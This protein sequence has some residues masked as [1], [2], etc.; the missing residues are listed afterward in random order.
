MVVSVKVRPL[1]VRNVVPVAL[2]ITHKTFLLAFLVN[3]FLLLNNGFD[4]R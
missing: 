3:G 2:H 1:F 4:V